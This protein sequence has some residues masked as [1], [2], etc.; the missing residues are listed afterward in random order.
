MAVTLP[1]KNIKL[2][3]H[4]ARK[5][6]LQKFVDKNVPPTDII[7]ISGHKNVQSILNYSHISNETHK[8]MS[9]ILYSHHVA[10]TSAS[11]R[12]AVTATTSSADSDL[13]NKMSVPQSISYR[14]P[15]E[16]SAKRRKTGE[17]LPRS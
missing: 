17:I 6:L 7:Q 5:G 13:I 14:D 2:T 1:N 9:N 3:N 15:N 8:Q 10:S 11:R 4:S 16:P 12:V